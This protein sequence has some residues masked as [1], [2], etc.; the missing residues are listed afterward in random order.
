M[1]MEVNIQAEWNESQGS[2]MFPSFVYSII[3]EE[4]DKLEESFSVS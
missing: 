4:T 2:N 3:R 1:E